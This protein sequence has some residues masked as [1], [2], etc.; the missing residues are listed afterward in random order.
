MIRQ[1]L[2]TWKD[3]IFCS[4]FVFLFTASAKNTKKPNVIF[5]LAGD[6]GYEDLSKVHGQRKA[7]SSSNLFK[8]INCV[9]TERI[10][11]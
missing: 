1:A 4:L 10:E 9:I 8:M 3:L 7:M 6:L 2:D 11:I 5:I